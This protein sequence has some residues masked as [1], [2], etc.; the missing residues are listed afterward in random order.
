MLTHRAE[1]HRAKRLESQEFVIQR[2]TIIECDNCFNVLT[3]EPIEAIDQLFDAEGLVL[4][5]C[6]APT[7]GSATI[8]DW[9]P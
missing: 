1:R 2:A 6:G 8:V 3:V 9:V 5:N 4:C 7:N